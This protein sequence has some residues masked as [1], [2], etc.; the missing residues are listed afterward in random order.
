MQTPFKPIKVRKGMGIKM[1]GL[2]RVTILLGAGAAIGYFSPRWLE[3]LHEIGLEISKIDSEIQSYPF[4]HSLEI[5][6][7]SA[8]GQDVAYLADRERGLKQPVTSG[9]QLGSPSYRIRGLYNEGAGYL[10]SLGE[11]LVAWLRR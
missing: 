3:P 1:R 11:R 7:E 4:P 8:F 10:L 5:I 9:F 6:V 2:L